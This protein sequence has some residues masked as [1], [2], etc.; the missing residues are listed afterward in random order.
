MFCKFM[1]LGLNCNVSLPHFNY[2][3][4]D[5]E[6]SKSGDI[7]SKIRNFYQSNFSSLFYFIAVSCSVFITFSFSSQLAPVTCSVSCQLSQLL[8][9][10][11]KQLD[12]VSLCMFLIVTR[13]QQC[14]LQIK[15]VNRINSLLFLLSSGECLIKI[16]AQC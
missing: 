4:T 8:L 2:T 1:A 12:N 10:L 11:S 5:G 15:L 9:Y 16:I 14:F 13:Q 3:D 7:L 6:K